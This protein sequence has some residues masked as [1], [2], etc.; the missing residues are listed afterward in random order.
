MVRRRG[1][2]RTLSAELSGSPCSAEEEVCYCSL[3]KYNS[4]QMADKLIIDVCVCVCVCVNYL[5]AQFVGAV[6]RRPLPLVPE[7]GRG[8]AP[9]QQLHQRL[10][11]ASHR[12]MEGGVALKVCDVHQRVTLH[13]HTSHWH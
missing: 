7:A 6:Q 4:V 12:L 3:A 11:S 9:Q 5:A 10:V 1:K 8:S 13:G 2:V